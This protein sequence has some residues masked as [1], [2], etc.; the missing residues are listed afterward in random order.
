MDFKHFSDLLKKL[1]ENNKRTNKVLIL[2]DFIKDNEENLELVGFILDVISGNFYREI[3]KKDYN[4]SLKTVFDV[5]SETYNV[6]REKVENYFNRIGDIGKVTLNF[7]KERSLLNKEKLTVE[8]LK[9]TLIKISRI[10]GSNSNKIKKELLMK[11]LSSCETT[12][13]SFF[14]TRIFINDLR[15][16]VAEGVIKEALSNYFL[17][18]ILNVN[19]L[20]NNCGYINLSNN[21]CFNCN[22]DIDKDQNFV[23]DKYE[24]KIY[25]NKKNL[26]NYFYVSKNEDL[27]DRELYNL[28]L[29]II[30][31]KYNLINNFTLFIKD[32]LE[33]KE[34]IFI[35]EIKLGRPIK[36]MLGIKVKS[37]K[38]AL[39]DMKKPYF[40]D[41]KYDG[42]RLQI[43]KEKDFVKIFSRNLEDITDKFPEVVE[44]FK[45]NFENV[46]FVLDSEGVGYDYNNLK[47]L[48]FQEFSKRFQSKN[49][50]EVKN[51]KMIVRAFDILYFNGETLI[52]KKYKKRREILEKLF[53][54][55][56]LKQKN[57]FD[58]KVIKKLFE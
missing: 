34:N 40:A 13:E 43:H 58:E 23:Y 57:Y 29:K 45:S 8:L 11:L 18:N 1:S 16:G 48:P 14:L 41:F 31:E 52:D 35:K 36:C 7:Y 10:S 49:Y 12:E 44:F 39:K 55:A 33:N 20:C 47:F 6:T 24:V 30:E 32:F 9:S 27:S 53:L 56:N 3:G 5:I 17:S 50:E 4:I 38:E 2:R 15:I 21:I 54:N 19:N 26:I 28:K 46:S 22:K 25:E 42:L 51:I 37:V